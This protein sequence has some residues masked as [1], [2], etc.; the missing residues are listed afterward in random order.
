MILALCFRPCLPSALHKAARLTSKHR[1]AHRCSTHGLKY[2]FQATRAYCSS[3]YHQHDLA[4]LVGFA[5]QHPVCQTR[6]SEWQ[7]VADA[8]FELARIQQIASS[9]PNRWMRTAFIGRFRACSFS[10]GYARMTMPPSLVVRGELLSRR[11]DENRQQA[12][13]LG[14]SVR[15]CSGPG[16]STQHCPAR[17]SMASPLHLPPGH[18][19]GCVVWNRSGAQPPFESRNSWN[20]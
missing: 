14:F 4:A 3:T 18:N 19:G 7:Y 12:C 2:G 20:G 5:R 9:P 13:R 17:Y 11:G 1:R 16:G 15:V 6:A 8:R 10:S